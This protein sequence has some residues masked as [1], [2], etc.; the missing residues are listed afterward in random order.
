MPR[1]PRQEQWWE[2]RKPLGS[3]KQGRVWLETATEVPEEDLLPVVDP[4]TILRVGDP[5]PPL[6]VQYA[7]CQ[8]QARDTNDRWVQLLQSLGAREGTVLDVTGEM[9][10][11]EDYA[12]LTRVRTGALDVRTAHLYSS[13]VGKA[14]WPTV[15]AVESWLRD[16]VAA[17]RDNLTRL[18]LAKL[19]CCVLA[20]AAGEEAVRSVAVKLESWWGFDVQH[21]SCSG[22]SSYMID[23]VSRVR[24]LLVKESMWTEV[25]LALEEASNDVLWDWRRVDLS[26]SVHPSLECEKIGW[27]KG[28]LVLQTEATC[29][30]FSSL[31]N[32]WN[33]VDGEASDDSENV[34][35]LRV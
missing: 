15:L 13:L 27:W 16:G 20:Q 32:G 19:W 23:R 10:A 4:A 25:Q 26:C 12:A 6:T 29:D 24:A 34:K 31:V 17:E 7:V 9:L 33:E 5:C 2:G 18:A 30:D 14:G 3:V 1:R 28:D 8:S 22:R 11:Y 21:A 35:P